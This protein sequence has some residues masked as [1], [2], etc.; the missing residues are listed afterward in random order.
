MTTP[1]AKARVKIDS[2]L[3]ESGWQIQD[4]NSIHL[5]EGKGIAIR[6]YPM[7]QGHGFADYLLFVGYHAIGVIEAKKDGTSLTGVEP[8][9]RKYSEGLPEDI[10]T[11]FTDHRLKYLYE[12]TGV[13]TRFTNA[14]D[15]IPKS[16]RIFAFHRP[17]TLSANFT[18]EGSI[19]QVPSIS[20]SSFV[21]QMKQNLP[22]IPEERLW[23]AQRRA[24]KKLE[25]SIKDGRQRHLIQMATGSGKTYMAIM[26][27][28]RMIQ[29]GGARRIVFLVDRGNLGR[30]ALREFQDFDVPRTGR[31]FTEIWN[32]QLL[33][34]NKIDPV[35]RVVIATVQRMYSMLKGDEEYDDSLEEKGL[36]TMEAL[37]KDTIPVTYNSEVPV[38]TFDVMIIDECHR[39][40][41]NL[42]RQVLEYFDANLIGLTATP[43]KQTIGFFQN[44]LVMEYGHRLAVVDAVNVDYNVYRIRTK[45]GEEG[46]TVEQGIQIEKRDRLTREQRW[47]ILDDDLQYDSSKL[48]RDV[49][50]LDQIRTVIRAYRDALPV[51]FPDRDLD[52]NYLKH[53]PKT[54][55]F[56][57]S[58][59]HADD[60]VKIVRDEF[61]K[62]NDFCQKITYKTTGAKPEDIL[63]Q[64]RNSYDPRIV[65]TVDMIATGTDVKPLEA[66]I[67]MRMVR[68]LNYFEQMKGRGVRIISEEALAKVTPDAKG[69]KSKFW[70]IDAVGVTEEHTQNE[71]PPLERSPGISFEKLLK[72]I[73]AGSIDED[74]HS[75]LAGRLAMLRKR[76]EPTQLNDFE[77]KTGTSLD[78]LTRKMVESVDPD[79]ILKT[80]RENLGMPDGTPE[81]SQLTQTMH[82]LM[83]EAISPLRDPSVR[84]WL[85]DTKQ[86]L[87]Q[88]IDHV[89]MD[90]LL[91]V[92]VSKEAE[93]R[94]KSIANS[95]EKWIE[96]NKDELIAL[97]HLYAR[98]KSQ[99]P[100]YKQIKEL[101]QKLKVSGPNLD[102]QIVW[103]AYA[104]LAESEGG[105]T[106]QRG[107]GSALADIVQL[108]RHAL[109]PDTLPL[110]PF[111]ETVED[112]FKAWLEKQVEQGTS[113]DKEQLRW[114]TDIAN[115]IG[116]SLEIQT[117]DFDYA[118]FSGRGGLGKAHSLFGERLAPILTELN[119]VLV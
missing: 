35:A 64:F 113:F 87:D 55:I 96:A 15:P 10:R 40:I 53:V 62:G 51:L 49:V 11:P 119:T 78:N 33:T 81:E 116:G 100:S 18:F 90:C 28:Y 117:D 91:E 88:V 118:P 13:E 108:V 7:K 1:E 111:S 84:E 27:A 98:P 114:L 101:R 71:S 57:K 115:H 23:P 38:E 48:D 97:Q 26:A 93:E 39:S 89:S 31:K 63:A 21:D 80:A 9:T 75:T 3:I 86:L 68:S 45:I 46:S 99:T 58:D 105:R 109:E 17:E 6:E 52:G 56:A 73:A 76:L 16:R 50:S 30:Q 54:L 19:G 110:A 44:N 70:I 34:S 14:N 104:T 67:F 85:M 41:Y 60:I 82:Q 83:D 74:V 112:R 77:E 5:Q 37:R 102:P 95:F 103:Q 61:G 94:C 72:A 92:L 32:V 24:V 43:A 59:N 8:Q 20:D 66:L 29:F 42:W 69:G 12:S 107:G 65:V 106:V 2:Q 47:E 4:Y 79:F 25:K 36:V 22:S